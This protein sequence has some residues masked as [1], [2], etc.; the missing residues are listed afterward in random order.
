MGSWLQDGR[1]TGN[2]GGEGM[3]VPWFLFRHSLNKPRPI[4][5]RLA[6]WPRISTSLSLR[7]KCVCERNRHSRNSVGNTSSLMRLIESKTSIPFW[8]KSSVYSYLVVDCWSLEHR[9][10]I[11]YKSCGR[12]WISFF[13]MCSP[14]GKSRYFI[15]DIP[16]ADADA[17]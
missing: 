4:W 17:S 8:V 11:I 14:L 16:I 15:Q 9:C 1:V 7:T 5:L 3:I 2:E 6:S 13:L 10:R 12:Y